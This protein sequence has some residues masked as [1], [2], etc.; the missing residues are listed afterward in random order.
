MNQPADSQTGRPPTDQQDPSAGQITAPSPRQRA[1]RPPRD[2]LLQSCPCTSGSSTTAPPQPTPGGLG[3]PPAWR[4]G[5]IRMPTRCPRC[6]SPRGTRT[7]ATA[8]TRRARARRSRTRSAGSRTT[9]AKGVSTG[10]TSRRT[11]PTRRSGIIY[12]TTRQRELHRRGLV[13]GPRREEEPDR[14][15][16]GLQRDRHDGH[17]ADPRPEGEGGGH[18]LHRRD[19]RPGD[20]LARDR[21]ED[22]ME[23]A[24]LPRERVDIPAVPARGGAGGA[25]LDGVISSGASRLRTPRRTWPG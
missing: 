9:S 25:N 15:Q 11:C 4:R 8:S 2:G 13:A 21:D 16:G 17:A 1:G 7:G 6:S 14:R 3:T 5:G 10:S 23:P 12:R 19:S 24:G 20:R 18:A 22:R